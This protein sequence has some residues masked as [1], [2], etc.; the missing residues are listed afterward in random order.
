MTKAE[1]TVLVTGGAGYIGSH[2]VLA[3]RE[4]GF[5]VVVL[6][7]LSTGYAD[8]VPYDVPLVEADVGDA[9]LLTDVLQRHR[10]NAVMHF[11]ASIVVPDSVAMPLDYY[12]NNVVNSHTLIA[13]C[14][15]T[16]VRHFVL[17]STAAVYGNPDRPDVDEDTIPQPINPYGASKLMAERMLADV[18]LAHDLRHV[19]LRYFNVAGADPAGRIGQRNPA[20]THLIKLACLTA[21]GRRPHC[22]IFGEDFPTPDGTGVR[23]YVHVTDLADA[24]VLALRYLLAGGPSLVANCGYGHGY[25]VR[26]VLRAVETAY[27]AALP[28]E[29]APRRPGDPAALVAAAGR[30]R[31]VLGW[32]PRFDDLD[33]IV[34]TALDWER[35]LQP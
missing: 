19:T 31:T 24:H 4:A 22:R 5:S 30:V 26:E 23:D 16:N 8:A 6:D 17:S 29:S 25:S 27:G 34:R 32:Q 21:L 33:A 9:G 7:N 15:A 1:T 10:I 14:V 12:R 28:V 3:L 35:R 18:A 20:A 11:A 13:A 2:A